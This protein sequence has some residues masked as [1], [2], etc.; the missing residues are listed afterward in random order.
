MMPADRHLWVVTQ[1]DVA[2]PK[3]RYHLFLCEAAPLGFTDLSL[4]NS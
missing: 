1:V 3:N 4:L 2:G